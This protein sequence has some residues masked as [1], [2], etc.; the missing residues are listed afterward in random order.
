MLRSIP[1]QAAPIRFIISHLVPYLN[2]HITIHSVPFCTNIIRQ[3]LSHSIEFCKVALIYVPIR[4]N[5]IHRLLSCSKEKP[6]C[7]HP[8]RSF[9]SNLIHY[10][11][12]HSIDYFHTTIHSV[13][14][15]P[16]RIHSIM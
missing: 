9:L 1:F 7:C 14:S 6:L 3:L 16:N 12:S 13:P 11:P 15:L 8:F 5:R 10:I 4:H 2:L